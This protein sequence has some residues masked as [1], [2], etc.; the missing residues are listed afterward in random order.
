MGINKEERKVDQ[1]R[2]RIEFCDFFLGRRL[3]IMSALGP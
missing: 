1:M 2:I 3:A